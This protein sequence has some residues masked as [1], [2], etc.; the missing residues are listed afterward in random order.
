MNCMA[1]DRRDAD[2]P[3][4]IA[5]DPRG[6]LPDRRGSSDRRPG[7][8]TPWRVDPA[9]DGRGSQ[10]TP[11]TAGQG[12]MGNFGGAAWRSSPWACCS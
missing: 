11:K 7:E 4:V 2:E 5:E 8:R 3:R 6:K 12:P 9:K 10:P 1:E